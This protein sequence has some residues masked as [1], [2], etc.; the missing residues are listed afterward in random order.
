MRLKTLL[1]LGTLLG[2]LAFSGC[3]L[4]PKETAHPAKLTQ[5]EVGLSGPEVQPAADGCV[6]GLLTVAPLKVTGATVSPINPI[7][8]G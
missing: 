7:L 6:E 1:P 5:D 3:V 8:V 2:T 4:P